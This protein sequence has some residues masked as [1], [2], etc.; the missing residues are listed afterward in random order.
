MIYIVLRINLNVLGFYNED[1]LLVGVGLVVVEI[2]KKY[3]NKIRYDF[4]NLL[5]I[6]YMEYLYLI[7]IR[8]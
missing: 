5:C 6:S 7:Y 2:L 1:G 3:K 8:S 4:C